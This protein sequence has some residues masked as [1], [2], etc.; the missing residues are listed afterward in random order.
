[1]EVHCSHFLK[2]AVTF[3]DFRYVYLVREQFG[4]EGE[5]V[6]DVILKEGQA[7]ASHIIVNSCLKLLEA[8]ENAGIKSDFCLYLFIKS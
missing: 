3:L 4:E 5:M 2:K 6:V 8:S 7:T 1:M